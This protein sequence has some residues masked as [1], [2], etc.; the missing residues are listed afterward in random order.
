MMKKILFV[1]LAILVLAGSANAEVRPMETPGNTDGIERIICRLF[2]GKNKDF[3]TATKPLAGYRVKDAAGK[4][5][6]ATV[7]RGYPVEFKKQPP[8]LGQEMPDKSR[9]P[10]ISV[11]DFGGKL[12]YMINISSGKMAHIWTID[13]KTFYPAFVAA[14]MELG[15]FPE[16]EAWNLTTWDSDKLGLSPGMRLGT[17]STYI[18]S[19]PFDWGKD[20]IKATFSGVSGEFTI[21]KS[22]VFSVLRSAIDSQLSVELQRQGV[23]SS[24]TV[25]QTEIVVSCLARRL[26]SG[27]KGLTPE[28]VAVTL[29]FLRN[30]QLNPDYKVILPTVI[31]YCLTE[32]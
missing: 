2:G 10:R 26:P 23:K 8:P 4:S 22:G 13:A 27:K 28:A 19:K 1:L 11:L 25:S 9:M 16:I 31:N 24:G 14:K 18:P 15:L 5:N 32:Q 20:G 7:M 29:D 21:E 3:S 30:T 17:Q 6:A 12:S